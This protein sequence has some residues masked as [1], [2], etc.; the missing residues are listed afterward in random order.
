MKPN[1]VNGKLQQQA[2]GNFLWL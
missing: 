1:T 2:A